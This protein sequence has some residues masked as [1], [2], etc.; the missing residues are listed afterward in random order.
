M[1]DASKSAIE[2]D[3]AAAVGAVVDVARNQQRIQLLG[4]AQIDDILPSLEGGGVKRIGH[5]AGRGGPQALEGAVQM[6]VG[7]VGEADAGHLYSFRLQDGSI[8]HAG[9][10]NVQRMHGSLRAFFRLLGSN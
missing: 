10:V 1:P 7:G 9:P 3:A 5:M 2:Q 4:N 6:Q 8:I